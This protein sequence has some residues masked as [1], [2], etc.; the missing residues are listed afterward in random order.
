MWLLFT[1]T[2]ETN[3]PDPNYQSASILVANQVQKHLILFRLSAVFCR[4]GHGYRFARSKSRYSSRNS[5]NAMNSAVSRY[6]GQGP[7]RSNALA[8]EGLRIVNR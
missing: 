3:R 4:A 1:A 5:N 2:G 6:H 8:F 7:M